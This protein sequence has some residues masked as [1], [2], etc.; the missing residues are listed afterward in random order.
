M[1]L[2]GFAAIMAVTPRQPNMECPGFYSTAKV[3]LPAP[4]QRDASGTIR[5]DEAEISSTDCHRAVA[6]ATG[7]R[8]KSSR[9]EINSGERVRFACCY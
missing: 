9:P 3:L 4:K 1:W 5:P 6:A 2:S 7:R 8:F